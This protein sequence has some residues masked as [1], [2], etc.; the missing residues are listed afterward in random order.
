MTALSTFQ[1]LVERRAVDLPR[2]PVSDRLA[3]YRGSADV[4]VS[5]RDPVGGAPKIGINP[6]STFNTPNGIYAYPID[7]AIQHGQMRVPYGQ[8]RP[9][10][11]VLQVKPD[12]NFLNLESLT[13]AQYAAMKPTL[14]RYKADGSTASAAEAQERM[15]SDFPAWERCARVG[16]P[17]GKLWNVTRLLVA[18]N[19]NKWNSV[20]RSI[21]GFDGVLD[22]GLA[23]IHGNE[24]TQAVFFSMRP[25]HVLEVLD[26]KEYESGAA[27]YV[28]PQTH[29]WL[30]R[31]RLFG[32]PG[33]TD[34][35]DLAAKLASAGIAEMEATVRHLLMQVFAPWMQSMAHPG[36]MEGI[37]HF[38]SV[39]RQQLG[40]E[41]D[42]A[43]RK[44]LL[45]GLFRATVQRA[46]Q[47]GIGR[48]FAVVLRSIVGNT[49]TKE[50]QTTLGLTVD[51]IQGYIPSDVLKGGGSTSSRN[52]L[53]SFLRAVADL[54][55]SPEVKAITTKS[56]TSW[57]TQFVQKARAMVTAD[58]QIHSVLRGT[59]TTLFEIANVGWWTREY[60]ALLATQ[61]DLPE[62]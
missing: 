38:V 48:V 22:P 7:Y 13:P 9:L 53:E 10:V 34:A 43:F 59:R 42:P 33:Y 45:S 41:F 6:K 8:S 17:A 58:N 40:G 29:A 61:L 55:V 54:V 16:T 62:N 46:L 11:Y 28:T 23:V 26:N 31:L 3:K 21:L 36:P 20:F 15:D 24:P 44:S 32:T 27:A 51:V 37:L 39:L 56:L 47:P 18:N 5:F 57:F 30:K 2:E 25:L 4:F 12:T 60:A 35:S 14:A 19:P 1:S 52:L 49:T 50:V